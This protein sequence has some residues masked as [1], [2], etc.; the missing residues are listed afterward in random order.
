MTSCSGLVWNLKFLK[1]RLCSVWYFFFP[2]TNYFLQNFNFMCPLD[3][4]FT[5]FEILKKEAE[6]LLHDYLPFRKKKIRFHRSK[7]AVSFLLYKKEKVW[8]LCAIIESMKKLK[9]M[10]KVSLKTS[11]GNPWF[12]FKY[13]KFLWIVIVRIPF[14]W[15]KKLFNETKFFFYDKIVGKRKRKQK[16][17]EAWNLCK[18]NKFFSEPRLQVQLEPNM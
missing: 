6:I 17:R 16:E 2:I 18:E 8:P 4:V 5:L 9:S 11:L 12:F 14:R 13:W 15:K 1:P 7:E 3:Y 10:Q